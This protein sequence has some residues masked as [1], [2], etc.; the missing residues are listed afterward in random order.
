MLIFV[1]IFTEISNKRSSSRSQTEGQ[2]TLT[3]Q[4]STCESGTDSNAMP[5]LCDKHQTLEFA[6]NDA[7]A[8]DA[9]PRSFSY[10]E[11]NMHDLTTDK[12]D[13]LK[14]ASNIKTEHATDFDYLKNKP[15]VRF[16]EPEAKPD[17]TGILDN[18]TM[19]KQSCT[20]VES[21]GLSVS[22]KSSDS[23]LGMAMFLFFEHIFS[24]FAVASLF[25]LLYSNTSMNVTCLDV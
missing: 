15:S 9:N 8:K 14:H 5:E 10:Q 18:E 1:A 20:S 17:K 16:N 3:F 2:E 11:L 13:E 7:K 6:S 23:N 25:E 22:H 21:Q 4:P 12:H 24:L 19:V